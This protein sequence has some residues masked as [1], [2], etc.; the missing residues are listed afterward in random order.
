M[1]T[2]ELIG[3]IRA[4]RPLL[5]LALKEEAQFLDTDLP[6]LTTGIGKVNAAAGLAA[7]LA[8]GQRPSEIINL[9]TA[10]ALKPGFSGLLTVGTTFQHDFNSYVLLQLTGESFSEPLRLADDSG[11]VLATGDVF[12]TDPERKAKLALHADLVDMEGYAVAA[13][14][15]RLGIPV[16]IIKH[17]SDQADE[18]AARTWQ[19]S[20]AASARVLASADL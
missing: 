13:V 11:V 5:V 2:L 3:D 4:D 8:G 9:G 20:V 1:T 10:G 18:H 19:Q 12:V 15:A 7:A 16:R 17:V 14:G 6:V